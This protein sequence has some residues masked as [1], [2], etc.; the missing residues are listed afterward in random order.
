MRISNF[1]LYYIFLWCHI[2][3]KK[4]AS[5]ATNL[6]KHITDL[7]KKKFLIFWVKR[8]A[9]C[10]SQD[11]IR[12]IYAVTPSF[13][14]QKLQ[15]TLKSF[16]FEGFENSKASQRHWTTF[17]DEPKTKRGEQYSCIMARHFTLWAHEK[18]GA[19]RPS[20][21]NTSIERSHPKPKI[22]ALKY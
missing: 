14:L 22:T 21:P 18:L 10:I 15:S 2:L 13:H 11:V 4:D 7:E 5:Y 8:S 6:I 17:R 1:D 12:N 9:M 20:S 16:C 19:S 3:N